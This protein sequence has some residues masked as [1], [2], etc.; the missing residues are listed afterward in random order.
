MIESKAWDWSKNESSS[1]L[2]PSIE[3]CYLSEVWR[4]KGFNK[5][6]D[7]G[8]GLGRHSI[9]LAKK[10]FEVN[11]VDLSD[12]G[13]NHLKKW[14]KE[15]QLNIDAQVCDMLNLP[16]EDNT[17]DCI[18]A[19][20]VIYHTDTEGFIKALNEI[21]RVLKDN[22]E[23]FITLISKNTWS[24]QSAEKYKR[25]DDNT[26]LRDE[27]ETEKDVPHFYVDIEDIKRYFID[28][29][30]VKIP[31]EETEYNMD[32][33]KYFSKHFKLIVSKK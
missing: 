28:F 9:Y 24:Y 23:L 10:G 2:V 4:S 32:N 8:C 11:A 27:H 16:F 6:L 14:A 15:E 7:L 12:Y 25:V 22:G 13:V 18:I 20:N 3:T 31:V 17:F 5:F 30:F 26:I 19:Y 29:D 1:W 33:T 21:K